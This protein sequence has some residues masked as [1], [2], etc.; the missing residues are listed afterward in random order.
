M[1]G[2]RSPPAGRRPA[3]RGFT[4]IELL[5]VVAIIAILVAILLPALK[6]A[7]AQAKRTKCLANTRQIALAWNLYVDDHGGQFLQHMNANYVYGGQQGAGDYLYGAENRIS[8]P[9]NR[10]LNLP[11]ITGM[12]LDI[13]DL[14]RGRNPDRGVEVYQCPTDAGTD[15]ARPSSFEFYGT[16]YQT[17]EMLVGQE[18]LYYNPDDPLALVFQ[19]VNRRLRRLNQSRVSNDARLILLGENPWS[20]ELHYFEDRRFQWHEKPRMHVV[21]YLD[22]HSDFVRIRKGLHV[23]ERYVTIPFHD[24]LNQ[25]ASLQVEGVR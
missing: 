21:A 5:V 18:Q 24:L 9:L 20:Y 17:N 4:L 23:L 15:E 12:F 25:A 19:Q 1:N 10:Y 22:G 7:R 16:S 3:A 13:N 2:R 11:L 6:S 14:T 8:K